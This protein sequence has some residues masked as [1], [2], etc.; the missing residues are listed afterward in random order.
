MSDE[1]GIVA[2]ADA[3]SELFYAIAGWLLV[4]LGALGL[5]AAVV[6]LAAGGG[7]GST[8]GVVLLMLFAF[9]LVASGVLVNPRLRRRLDRRHAI[10][11]FGRV[12]NTDRRVVRPD[13]NCSEPYV[14]CGT[15]VKSGTVR[16]YREEYAV[17]EIPFYTRSEGYNHY[18]IDCALSGSEIPAGRGRSSDGHPQAVV[19]RRWGRA[20]GSNGSDG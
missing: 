10:T 4:G 2:V 20:A 6:G 3:V 18:C 13:E 16:R 12:R 9:V 8:M 15:A 1:G 17:A 14:V 19:E 5:I 11:R 7:V